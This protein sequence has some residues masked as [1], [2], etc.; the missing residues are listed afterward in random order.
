MILIN[1]KWLFQ[2]VVSLPSSTLSTVSWF[3]CKLTSKKQYLFF[4]D[5][6]KGRSFP[7]YNFRALFLSIFHIFLKSGAW[8]HIILFHL[9]SSHC[10]LFFN[11]DFFVQGSK[12]RIL[13]T[14]VVSTFPEFIVQASFLLPVYQSVYM[15]ICVFFF[16]F[17]LS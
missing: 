17:L 1:R 16:C 15:F 8:A 14:E 10:C 7:Y 4:R 6:I 11:F 3:R 5:F 9:L 13:W 2:V 12:K